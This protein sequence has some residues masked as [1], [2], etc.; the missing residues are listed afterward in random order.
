MAINLPQITKVQ[1][2]NAILFFLL[3]LLPIFILWFV[4]KVVLIGFL[5]CIALRYLELWIINKYGDKLQ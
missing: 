5:G 2:T 1:R 3:T 4:D